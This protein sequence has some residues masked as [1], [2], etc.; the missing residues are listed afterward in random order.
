MKSKD[1]DSR[2]RHTCFELQSESKNKQARGPPTLQLSFFQLVLS[3]TLYGDAL[4]TAYLPIACEEDFI[5]QT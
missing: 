1:F 4:V 3:G 5:R 2:T